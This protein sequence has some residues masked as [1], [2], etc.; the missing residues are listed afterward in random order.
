VTPSS[1]HESLR[2][3]ASATN[4]YNPKY[5]MRAHSINLSISPARNHFTSTGA[6]KWIWITKQLVVF[7]R[8]LLRLVTDQRSVL[9]SSDRLQDDALVFSVRIGNATFVVNTRTRITHFH[10]TYGGSRRPWF[11]SRSLSL[12]CVSCYLCSTYYGT[13]SSSRSP[14]P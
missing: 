12:G 4:V 14:A 6:S 5:L 10:T 8:L 11:E 2:H 3:E 7:L 9:I 13:Q 1:S